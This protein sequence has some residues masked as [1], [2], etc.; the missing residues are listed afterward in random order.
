MVAR[1][2]KEPLV[3]FLLAGGI[4]FAAYSWLSPDAAGDGGDSQ[5]VL[6]QAQFDHLTQLWRAQ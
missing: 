4:L 5:I 1:I 6:N 3:Q 2:F